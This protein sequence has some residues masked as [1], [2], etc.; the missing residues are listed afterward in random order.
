MFRR[1]WMSAWCCCPIWAAV[2]SPASVSA[3]ADWTVFG[4]VAAPVSSP[5]SGFFASMPSW[6]AAA[7]R[8]GIWPYWPSSCPSPVLNAPCAAWSFALICCCSC[9]NSGSVSIPAL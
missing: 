3:C 2:E 5:Y 6:A 4:F 8:S 7:A 1:F 9:R